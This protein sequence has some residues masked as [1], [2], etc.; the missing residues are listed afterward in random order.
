PPSDGTTV[1]VLDEMWHFVNGKPN[2]V[3]IWKAYDLD[4]HKTFAWKLGRRDAATL[5]EFL[6]EI[7]LDGREFVTD[8]YE[9][10]HQLIPEWKLYTGKDLT[11]P[12]EQDNSNMR[13]YVGRFRRRSKITSRSVEMVDLSLLLLYH[14]HHGG[15]FEKLV[16]T[17]HQLFA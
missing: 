2:K 3:W 10:Y 11:F 8:D 13:H 15:L 4:T 5:K 7:G 6:D 16:E 1:V 9:A 12:I 14:V 17:F